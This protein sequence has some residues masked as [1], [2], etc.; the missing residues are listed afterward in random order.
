MDPGRH[1]A[2]A[3]RRC[4]RAD[5]DDTLREV[6]PSDPPRARPLTPSGSARRFSSEEVFSGSDDV[7]PAPSRAG[8]APAPSTSTPRPPS[9]SSSRSRR[10]S[11]SSAGEG[12]HPDAPRDASHPDDLPRSRLGLD[13]EI[14]FER[15]GPAASVA[16]SRAKT[17]AA[18]RRRDRPH[19]LA[20]AR[21]VAMERA[22]ADRREHGDGDQHPDADETADET[23]D[24]VA[25]AESRERRRR[26]PRRRRRRRRVRVVRIRVRALPCL[27]TTRAS[28][29]GE[30]LFNARPGADPH[31][32]RPSPTLQNCPRHRITRRI[33]DVTTSRGPRT[34]RRGVARRTARG[35]KF[36]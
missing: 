26:R 5:D 24:L 17:D 34:R 14:A 9:S 30:G 2:R 23:V 33:I 8:S 27:T 15:R 1:T 22:E 4:A 36:G 16:D 3:R 11:R 28:S 6:P 13:T 7:A 19:R 18:L 29:A 20:E 35:M 10:A 31:T 21:L 12:H 32:R 25:A